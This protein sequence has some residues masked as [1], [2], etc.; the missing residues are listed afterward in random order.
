MPPASSAIAQARPIALI[1][2]MG[3]GKTEA[4]RLLAARLGWP[5][6]DSDA[7]VERAAGCTV[8]ELFA[9]DGEAQFRERERAVIARLLD[10]ARLVLATGGGAILD[11]DTR[12]LLRER[13]LTIWLDAAPAVLGSRVGGAEDRPLLR[14]GDRE[15]VLARLLEER[16]PFYAEA[17]VHIPTDG[18]SLAHVVDAIMAAM[19]QQAG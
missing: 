6:H 13:T 12:V 14:G 7:E 2:M 19:G 15:T 1:G 10:G 17:D 11:A 16:R 9:R 18:R 8:A 4:G 5:F 3:A